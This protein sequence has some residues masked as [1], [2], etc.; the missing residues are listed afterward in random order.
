M[1]RPLFSQYHQTPAVRVEPE[2]PQQAYEKWTISNAFDPDSDEFFERSDA[3]YEAFVPQDSTAL[4]PPPALIEA[5]SSSSSS[6]ASSSG[7][8]SP[9]EDAP[10]DLS[11]EEIDL[12]L[13]REAVLIRLSAT[14][15]D[16]IQRRVRQ[17]REAFADSHSP[18][19]NSLVDTDPERI[20][21]YIQ[22]LDNISRQNQTATQAAR[23]RVLPPPSPT[24]TR[25]TLPRI[26]EPAAD[27]ES[28]SADPPAQGGEQVTTAR[29][30][31][32]PVAVPSAVP[33]SS[34]SMPRLIP[35]RPSTPPSVPRLS[36]TPST[37]P[38]RSPAVGAPPSPPPSVTPRLYS[39]SSRN[40]VTSTPIS[41]GLTGPLRNRDARLSVEHISPLADASSLRPRPRPNVRYVPRRQTY[42]PDAPRVDMSS[43]IVS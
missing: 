39:W 33:V 6:E 21:R 26:S 8:G 11:T 36:D 12:A 13:R 42:L 40:P 23:E 7:R 18:V 16:E 43:W 15:E 38:S 25:D 1:G 27:A 24:T 31:P 20:L 35:D 30:I 14:R 9:T 32:V 19:A 22:G 3:V 41:P 37:P 29:G 10:R 4:P 34:L 17:A 5:P 28:G 2:Q